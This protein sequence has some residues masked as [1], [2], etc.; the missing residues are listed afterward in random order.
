MEC[1]L[2]EVYSEEL[3]SSLDQDGAEL[4]LL[5][6]FLI[7]LEEQKHKDAYKLIE[8]IK[9]LESDIQVVERRHEL[10]K[11]LLPSNLQNGS[12]CQK[13]SAF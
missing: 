10:R 9:C 6:H 13:E 3:S 8:E 4:G 2:Q 11:C 7:S 12:S 1:N 5:L